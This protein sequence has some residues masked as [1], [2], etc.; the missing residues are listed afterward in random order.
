M[1]NVQFQPYDRI[2]END[3]GTQHETA[4]YT[5]SLP[6]KMT[7]KYKGKWDHWLIAS[8]MIKTFIVQHD[9]N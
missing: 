4:F 1:W 8:N 2:E 3:V 9:Q 5:K 7:H 6:E